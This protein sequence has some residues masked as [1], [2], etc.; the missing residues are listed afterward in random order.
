MPAPRFYPTSDEVIAIHALQIELHGGA[1]GLRDRG[2]L[3]AAIHR[4]QTG[5]YADLIEEAA[6]LWESLSQNHCFVDGNKRVAIVTT[7]VFLQAN[8]VRVTASDE[9][10]LAFVKQ[11]YEA[12]TFD[13]DVVS[14]WLR[15]NTEEL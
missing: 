4:P 10:R 5:Y 2:Q 8:G 6:A 11:H 7:F 12:M 14:T 1:S 9:E 13:F 3:E 15:A